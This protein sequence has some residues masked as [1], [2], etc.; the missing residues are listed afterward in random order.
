MSEKESDHREAISNQE[1]KHSAEI[2]NLKKLLANS[3]ATN[4]DLQK[5]VQLVYIP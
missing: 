4:T 2:G 5:E 1:S 3:E